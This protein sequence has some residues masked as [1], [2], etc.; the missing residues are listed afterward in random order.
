MKLH[1]IRS[2][3]SKIVSNKRKRKNKVNQS[4]YNTTRN[5]KKIRKNITQN[6]GAHFTHRKNITKYQSTSHMRRHITQNT[7][8]RSTC[9]KIQ[10]EIPE[11]VP[12]AEKYNTK[13]QSDFHTRKNITKNI[14]THFTRRKIQHKVPERVPN[15]EI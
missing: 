3:K 14:K 4:K 8:A 15:T 13:Y 1:N 7:T 11:R 6:T 12:H 2:C 9:G 5:D 10:H